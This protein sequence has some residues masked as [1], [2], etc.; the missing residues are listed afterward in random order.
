MEDTKSL[1][2]LITD[3]SNSI[4]SNCG[5]IRDTE[6]ISEPLSL[7]FEDELFISRVYR[8]TQMPDLARKNGQI[9]LTDSTHESEITEK[10]SH[11][12]V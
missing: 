7:D 10:R 6:S 5:S 1:Q 12:K 9:L 8:K 11:A 4:R 2:L 3:A